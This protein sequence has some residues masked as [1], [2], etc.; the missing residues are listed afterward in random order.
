MPHG[1]RSSFRD[2]AAEEMDHLRQG[3]EAA[4]AHVLAN[5]TAAAYTR[6]DPIG[7]RR[8]LMDDWAAYLDGEPVS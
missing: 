6:S 3:I 2:W 4:P 8:S 5:Q 1:V 7:W